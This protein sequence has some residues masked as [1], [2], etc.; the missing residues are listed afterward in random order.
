M[1]ARETLAISRRSYATGGITV[2]PRLEATLKRA[3]A[4]RGQRRFYAFSR[5]GKPCYQCGAEIKRR[6]L[7]GRRLY[8]CPQCQPG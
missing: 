3:G 2:A 7:A 6:E 4:T 1:L 5:D 8:L